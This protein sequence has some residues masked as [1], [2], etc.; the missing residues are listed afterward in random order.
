MFK[1]I[2]AFQAFS[3][4]HFRQLQAENPHAEQPSVESMLDVARVTGLNVGNLNAKVIDRWYETG[5]YNL[6][7]KR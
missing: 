7:K 2:H 5:W 1:Q 3:A 4:N 6:F